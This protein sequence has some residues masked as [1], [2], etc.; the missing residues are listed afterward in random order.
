MR[1]TLMASFASNALEY[2]DHTPLC[3]LRLAP[4]D[5]KFIVSCGPKFILQWM[6]RT[7]MIIRVLSQVGR[8]SRSG[9]ESYSAWGDESTGGH[10]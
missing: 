8:E 6:C 9:M 5:Y 3:D 7:S 2:F 4:R 10:P 1:T